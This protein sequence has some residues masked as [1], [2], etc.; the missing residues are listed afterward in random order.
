MFPSKPIQSGLVEKTCNACKLVKPVDQFYWV[1]TR[2]QYHGRCKPC[3][4]LSVAGVGARERAQLRQQAI[5]AYG[6]GCACCGESWPDYLVLDH[7]GGDG[8]AHR[9]G[10]GGSHLSAGEK[11]YRWLRNHGYPEGFQVLCA[12]CNMAK[13]RG[14][15]PTHETA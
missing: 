7:K 8:N 13:E 12:N 4:R 15:C 9:R 5:D 6:G 3:F 2:N 11:T 14:G 1:K 10:I